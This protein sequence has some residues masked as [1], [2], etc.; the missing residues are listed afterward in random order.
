MRSDHLTILGY[1]PKI[2]NTLIT[3]YIYLCGLNGTL[4]ISYYH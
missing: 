2:V 3:L 1:Y 4:V